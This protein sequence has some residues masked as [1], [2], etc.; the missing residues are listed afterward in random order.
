VV[1]GGG[2]YTAVETIAGSQG[3]SEQFQYLGNGVWQPVGSWLVS[4]TNVNYTAGNVGVGTA[5][6]QQ[7]LS[8]VGGLN[9]DQANQNP[10]TIPSDALTFG[11]SSGE[12]FAS[13]RTSGGSQDD[14]EFYTGYNNRLEILNNG[15]VGIGT[16]T[17]ANP[18]EVA[19]TA[20]F[21]G[22]VGVGT[23][24]PQ[25]SLSVVGGLNIDQA[26]L[27][28]GYLNAG[29]GG[30]IG[31]S[32]AGL[33]FGVGDSGEGIASKRTAGGNQNGLDFY[34]AW[35]PRL[36]I[37]NNGNVGI[38]KN[39]PGSALDVNG[40]ITCTSL[41]Q[42][43]DRNA[44]EK[45]APINP[46]AVLDKVA[47]LPITQWNF[48]TDAGTRHIGPMAQDFHSAFNV[49][50]DD[51]HIATVDE[52]GVALAAI[53]GLNQKFNAKDAEI[54]ALKQS[55]AELKQMVQTLAAKK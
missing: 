53:Q 12:G 55:V 36:S 37:A 43:S 52:E 20:Q 22:N 28:S 44:K 51:K 1:N 14:L 50:T 19:G 18:L 7:S 23:G 3:S 11:S 46:Q 47:A 15:N 54:E 33:S 45:F 5:S 42:T 9:I 29:N 2:I 38:N 16:S 21:D 34:T 24:S 25:Q 41:N 49:G 8:V 40:T 48:K 35:N 32:G 27:N 30:Q 13:Q 39:N 6:P 31:T 10:G 26:G 17:P 4:G